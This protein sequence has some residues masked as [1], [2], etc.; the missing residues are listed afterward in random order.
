[1]IKFSSILSWRDTFP[2]VSNFTCHATGR[3]GTWDGGAELRLGSRF[4]YFP[5]GR[6]LLLSRLFADGLASDYL[7]DN[8]PKQ[9]LIAAV[10]S[11]VFR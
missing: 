5:S 6:L 7:H 2:E 11:P 3:R 1:V 8:C 9:P 4:Q 10:I